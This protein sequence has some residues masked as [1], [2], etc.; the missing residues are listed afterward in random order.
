MLRSFFQN[1]I[2]YHYIRTIL[3][4]LHRISV[5][6]TMRIITPDYNN[7]GTIDSLQSLQDQLNCKSE[8][9]A[10]NMWKLPSQKLLHYHIITT[11][12]SWILQYGY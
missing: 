2:H 12:S 4:S 5:I 10:G 8:L 7:G 9:Q 3:Q 1:R 11:D 6:T